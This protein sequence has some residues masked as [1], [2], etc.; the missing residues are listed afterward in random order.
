MSTPAAPAGP[1]AGSPP[2]PP[3]RPNK[4]P[5]IAVVGVLVALIAVIGIWRVATG[6]KSDKAFGGS[7]ATSKPHIAIP[8]ETSVAPVQ[9]SSPRVTAPQ[10]GPIDLSHPALTTLRG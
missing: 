5:F 7:T 4:P 2:G 10:S 9:T 6:G 8:G 1:P 3:R